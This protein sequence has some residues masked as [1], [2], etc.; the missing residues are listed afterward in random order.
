MEHFDDEIKGRQFDNFQFVHFYEVM[1]EES[2]NKRAD[3][4]KH[5]MME[6]PVQYD[7]IKKHMK[8]DGEPAY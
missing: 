6:I 3:F 4:A 1:S 5:A 8:I 7:F 2:E